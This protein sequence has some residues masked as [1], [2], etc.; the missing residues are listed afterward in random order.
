MK[1][2]TSPALGKENVP[3]SSV[4]EHFLNNLRAKNWDLLARYEIDNI[5]SEPRNANLALII[6]LAKRELKDLDGSRRCFEVALGWGATAADLASY[7]T[8][9]PESI[10]EQKPLLSADKAFNKNISESQNCVGYTYEIIKTSI[11]GSAWAGSTVNTS[12]FRHHALITRGKSQYVA[13]YKDSTTINITKITDS[14]PFEMYELKGNYDLR[15]A[16]NGIS[17]GCD[18]GGFLHL[19]YDHHGTKLRYRRALTP[20]CISNWSE[21]LIMTG[22][23]ETSVTY[24]SFIMSKVG[25]RM[26]LLYRDGTWNNGSSRLKYYEESSHTWHD[27]PSPI[28]SGEQQI[29]W[30]AN[31]YW[32]HPA[33]GND[34]S[35]HLS[36]VWR[37]N[38]IGKAER[39]NNI[40]ICYAKSL[41]NGITWLTSLDQPLELPITP[42]NTET[43]FA[44][45]PGSNLINQCSMALDSCNQPHIAF[46]TND[47]ADIPQYYHLWLKQKRWHIRQISDRTNRFQLEG[48]GTLNLPISRP[49]IIVDRNDNVHV[50]YRGD[51]T[52]DRLAINS[53]SAPHYE[54]GKQTIIW[55]EDIGN[56]EP[57]IDRTKWEADQTLSI[58]AQRATQVNGDIATPPDFSIASIVEIKIICTSPIN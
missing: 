33:V 29:P 58:Y 42:V 16:H 51:L 49:E 43:V 11:L 24:P 3:Q 46:Y 4:L 52:A 53:A 20:D 35:L 13:F 32:N 55:P 36:Y 47:S 56:S 38:S 10:L 17:I 8:I 6:A 30:T 50:I 39:L 54:D 26:A 48:A 21:E 27:H 44:V 2:L 31:P 28:L 45:S 19:T 40:N 5:A 25:N 9:Q 22:R 14:K 34:G 41:D 15:D 1:N 7:L 18:R 37:T 57:I 12:I 23:Y